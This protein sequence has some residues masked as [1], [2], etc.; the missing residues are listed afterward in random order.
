MNTSVILFT[1][2]GHYQKGVND[3][4]KDSVVKRDVLGYYYIGEYHPYKRYG[5]YNPDFDEFSSRILKYKKGERSELFYFLALLTGILKENSNLAITCVPSHESGSFGPNHVIISML[6]EN[7]GYTNAS[8]CL[9]RF[10]T[11]DKLATGGERS[12]S[13]HLSSIILQDTHL[14]KDRDVLLIDDVAT[15]GNSLLACS[16]IIA[17]SLEIRTLRCLVFGKTV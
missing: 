5:Q 7:R 16:E 4:F 11:V 12:K 1:K 17:N 15:S 2:R 6:C 13:V 10:K 9:Y 14:L 8:S 3:M